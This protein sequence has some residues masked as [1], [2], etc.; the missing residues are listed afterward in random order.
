MGATEKRDPEEAKAPSDFLAVLSAPSAP[1]LVW[2]VAILARF[3]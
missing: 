3:A 1:L 2:S